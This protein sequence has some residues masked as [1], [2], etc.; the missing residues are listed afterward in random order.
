MVDT[1]TFTASLTTEC[2]GWKTVQFNVPV[3]AEYK[4]AGT[5]A[6]F[7]QRISTRAELLPIGKPEATPDQT[8]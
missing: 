8:R 6:E 3:T 5:G 7:R 1:Y 4:D 2:E